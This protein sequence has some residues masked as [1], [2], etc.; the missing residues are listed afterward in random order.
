[1]SKRPVHF[2]IPSNSG[3]I[4]TEFEVARRNH[5]SIAFC[6][7]MRSEF[8][9]RM[10]SG[11]GDVVP[12]Y[13]V[14]LH[15]ILV[16]PFKLDALSR[17]ISSWLEARSPFRLQLAGEPD[18][19]L[20]VAVGPSDSLVSSREKPVLRLVFEGAPTFSVEWSYVVDQTC[21]ATTLDGLN[22]LLQTLREA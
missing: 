12:Q 13:D 6:V 22:G 18:Q 21:L 10:Q 4:T 19:L 7:R 15:Q 14:T 8:W 1:M 17:A 16:V 11:L 3:R 2:S 5:S 9:E 20:S